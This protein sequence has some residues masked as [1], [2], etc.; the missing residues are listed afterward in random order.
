MVL[1]PSSEKRLATCTTVTS[2][3][4][5]IFDLS[6]LRLTSAL[7]TL[8]SSRKWLLFHGI[9]PL[10]DTWKR[11]GLGYLRGRNGRRRVE[12]HQGRHI[13]SSLDVALL[14]PPRYTFLSLPLKTNVGVR[15]VHKRGIRI[16]RLA[17][18]QMPTT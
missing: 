13:C 9:R 10:R 1:L 17:H 11:R 7:N 4:I 3:S 2:C 16:F 5:G 15:M 12:S 18:L 8:E 14:L 6:T